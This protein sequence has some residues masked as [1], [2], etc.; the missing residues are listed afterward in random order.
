MSSWVDR[1]V[2]LPAPPVRVNPL[3]VSGTVALCY[4]VASGNVRSLPPW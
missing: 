3:A 2:G 1:L 4:T